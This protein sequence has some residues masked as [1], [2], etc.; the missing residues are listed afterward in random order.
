MMKP[1][2][3]LMVLISNC[4]FIWK[5]LGPADEKINSLPGLRPEFLYRHNITGASATTSK[6]YIPK[7]SENTSIKYIGLKTLD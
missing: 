2:F 6:K 3:L 4:H 5:A 7:T 1:T